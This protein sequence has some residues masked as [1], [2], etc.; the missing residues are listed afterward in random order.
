MAKPELKLQSTISI[1]RAVTTGGAPQEVE[2]IFL[3]EGDILKGIPKKF[4]SAF[5]PNE[6]GSICEGT[7]YGCKAELEVNSSDDKL[8]KVIDGHGG[9]K[10]AEAGSLFSASN[11]IEA[12]YTTRDGINGIL[13]RFPV[14]K[15]AIEGSATITVKLTYGLETTTSQT[16]FSLSQQ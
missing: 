11:K 15:Q 6:K 3:K 2:E 13:L 1:K 14:N 5:H 12:S 8:T 10:P 9:V 7:E 16:V 4:A